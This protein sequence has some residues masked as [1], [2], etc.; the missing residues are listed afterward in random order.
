MQA[1]AAERDGERSA[2]G[3]PDGGNWWEL[4]CVCTLASPC[5]APTPCVLPHS[6]QG[7]VEMLRAVFRC[8]GSLMLPVWALSTAGSN[9][10]PRTTP[11]SPLGWPQPLSSMLLPL[12]L[13]PAAG[14]SRSTSRPSPPA[15][16]A[17]GA[18]SPHTTPGL[19]ASCCSQVGRE[20]ALQAL[21]AAPRCLA[22]RAWHAWQRHLDE[23][24]CA[25]HAPPPS[26]LCS[27]L[28]LQPPVFMGNP[29]ASA[30]VRAQRLAH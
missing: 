1:E 10:V 21:A 18:T 12:F 23:N 24:M 29:R 3:I 30:G 11:P 9:C 20:G 7:H 25:C 15:A 19:I 17:A 22:Y 13:R 14:S 4:L 5:H 28:S 16:C 26:Q 6:L 8:G 2:D 27:T